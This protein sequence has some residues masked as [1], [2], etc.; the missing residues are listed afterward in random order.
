MKS[1]LVFRVGA[2]AILLASLQGACFAQEVVGSASINRVF[3][4]SIVPVSAQPYA[5]DEVQ[6]S[7]D[8]APAVSASLADAIAAINASQGTSAR[9]ELSSDIVVSQTY[10]LTGNKSVIIDGTASG[11]SLTRKE[12]YLGALI[13][14][15]AGSLE[16]TNVT[17]DGDVSVNVEDELSW[18]WYGT[19]AEKPLIEARN[20]ALI[21]SGNTVLQNARNAQLNAQ[22]NGGAISL[23]NAS[24]TMKDGAEI[25]KCSANNNGGAIYATGSGSVVTLEK[26]S[27]SYCDATSGGAVYLENGAR[28]V[29]NGSTT[30]D[31]RIFTN[32]ATNG[33]AIYATGSVST[34]HSLN[35]ISIQGNR[36]QYGG[37]VYAANGAKFQSKSANHDIIENTAA[38]NGGAFYIEGAGSEV[39]LML[40]S[41]QRNEAQY[42]GAVYVSDRGKFIADTVQLK[43]NQ[44]MF[45]GG[46]VYA[47][48]GATVSLQRGTGGYD[49]PNV[50]S[51][52]LQNTAGGYGGGIYAAGAGTQIT[53]GDKSTVGIYD[54]KAGFG[55]GALYLTNG[56][57]GTL[58]NSV[59]IRRNS[60]SESSEPTTPW[61]VEFSCGGVY[62]YQSA[63]LKLAGKII[64]TENTVGTEG[65]EVNLLI[66]SGKIAPGADQNVPVECYWDGGKGGLSAGTKIGVSLQVWPTDGGSN[67]VLYMVGKTYNGSANGITADY[68][69]YFTSDR[70]PY[71][72]STGKGIFE[73]VV[74]SAPHPE[75]GQNYNQVY[76]KAH[77]IQTPT[78]SAQA[79]NKYYDGT[80][81]TSLTNVAW[82]NVDP[83][84][85]K[86]FQNLKE[87]TDYT[88]TATFENN[89]QGNVIFD[90]TSAKEQ[91]VQITISV[92]NQDVLKVFPSLRSIKLTSKAVIYPIPL[93]IKAEAQDK[94]YDA[95][96]AAQAT[97]S[98]IVDTSAGSQ[99][100]LTLP[101]TFP[102]NLVQGT[103]Y[104]V[105]ASFDSAQA[106]AGRNVNIQVKPNGTDLAKNYIWPSAQFTLTAEILKLPLEVSLQAEN[107]VYD[108][109]AK[110]VLKGTPSVSIAKQNRS[111]LT[112]PSSLPET[113]EFAADY[114]L[115]NPM[116]ADENGQPV[117]D[118]GVHMVTGTLKILN[119][120][121]M[122]NYTMALAAQGSQAE[123]TQRTLTPVSV[124]VQ[125]KLYDGTTEAAASDLVLSGLPD[126]QKL[127]EGVDYRIVSAL[128]EDAETGVNK[129]VRVTFELLSEQAKRN[130]VLEKDFLLA[131]ADI[132]NDLKVTD[133]YTEEVS[134]GV[135]TVQD[136][137]QWIRTQY[138]HVPTTLVSLSIK[139]A[140]GN[141]VQQIDRSV[142][143]VYSVEARFTND[144]GQTALY[145]IVWNLVEKQV[146]EPTVPGETPSTPE[147]TPT[148]P[149]ASPIVQT[150]DTSATELLALALAIS[151]TAIAVL[152]IMGH[153]RNH[154]KQK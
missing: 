31:V 133:E 42:G 102:V 104:T 8:G 99:G 141:D 18:S 77:P 113:I 152:M 37:A 137:E 78:V 103:D 153:K 26:T 93:A 2:A 24:L 97:I 76:L 100:G 96:N 43:G 11:C 73:T 46:A 21:L 147:E 70:N 4:A 154:M 92:K 127:E 15:E 140:N 17:M 34:A 131:K 101:Q 48:G 145:Q 142:A 52:V 68:A 151:A 71:D 109:S 88:Y 30:G 126:G 150:G 44:A 67:E 119:D 146:E 143:A 40:T 29:A 35:L 38:K 118:A 72:S 139:D 16:L 82:S 7:I 19:F 41:L 53:I 90:G 74:R 25:Q 106:G 50:N 107:K 39:N 148:P 65:R 45:D 115:E 62:V 9:I 138:Y 132:T 66:A 114:T 80:N 56:S 14:V 122:K 89:A 75:M 112:L 125:D 130:Y 94:Y 111:G 58:L 6:Y 108:G 32:H 13:A 51:G 144:N 120:S 91:T 61:E 64:I 116:F 54:N 12:D 3:G 59:D 79:V 69:G 63:T 20:A 5:A 136:M 117:S 23:D 121:K 28:L 128:F 27:I 60:G 135:M 83:A 55:A 81:Q 36:A 49:D 87:G 47:K 84:V 123:I 149:A 110:A 1:K 129:Q 86:L 98:L 134:S 57:V 85:E 33:A 22:N 95:T 105:T 124:K 10:T